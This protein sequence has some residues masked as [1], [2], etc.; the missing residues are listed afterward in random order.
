VDL[1]TRYT[2]FGLP[3]ET[4]AANSIKNFSPYLKENTSTSK[5]NNWL[6][7]FNEIIYVCSVNHA[8]CINALRGQNEELYTVKT[9]GTYNYHRLFKQMLVLQNH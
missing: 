1:S 4:L 7:L 2:V 6:I 9:G 5:K 8:K 3:C